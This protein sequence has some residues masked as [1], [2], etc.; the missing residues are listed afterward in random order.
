MG[1]MSRESG[2]MAADVLRCS[3]TGFLFAA[4][5]QVAT[6]FTARGRYERAKGVLHLAEIILRSSG[7]GRQASLR[8]SLIEAHASLW[9]AEQDGRYPS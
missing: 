8:E 6:D 7:E 9:N 3:D 5:L 2:D 1:M 4:A